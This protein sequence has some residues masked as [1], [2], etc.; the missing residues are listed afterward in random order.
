MVRLVKAW[1]PDFFEKVG[2][3][4]LEAGDVPESAFP[5]VNGGGDG[6]A[7]AFDRRLNGRVSRL[8]SSSPEAEAVVADSVRAVFGLGEADMSDDEAIDRVM[9]PA[10]NRHRLGRAQRVVPFAADAGPAPLELCVR[11]AGSATRPIHRTSATGWY[12]RRGRC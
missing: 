6:Y 3:D 7:A 5:R 1:D 10:R 12:R 9:N 11:E 8:R 2:M 4:P